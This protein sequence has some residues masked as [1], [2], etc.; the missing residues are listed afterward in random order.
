MSV[1]TKNQD[2]SEIA[3][4]IVNGQTLQVVDNTNYLGLIVDKHLHWDDH[5]Q[6]CTSK[7]F[8]LKRLRKILPISAVEKVYFTCIQPTLEYAYTVWSNCT[9]N[10]KGKI[11]RLQNLAAR[12]ILNNFDHVNFT[13][14]DLVDKLGWLKSDYRYKYLISVL[15]NV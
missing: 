11:Q 10:F 8:M 6:N 7:L 1:S 15:I 3:P 13:G 4:P 2:T 5:L 9:V 14:I 12:I